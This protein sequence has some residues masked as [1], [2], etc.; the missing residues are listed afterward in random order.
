MRINTLSFFLILGIISS[1]ANRDIITIDVVCLVC[2]PNTGV[3]VYEPATSY[4][5]KNRF[6]YRKNDIENNSMS[7][8]T[9]CKNSILSIVFA[10]QLLFG[11]YRKIKI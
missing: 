4:F 10:A 7:M 6:K 1:V 9:V 3:W 11:T 2:G 8:T 5:P